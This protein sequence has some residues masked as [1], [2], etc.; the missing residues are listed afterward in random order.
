MRM[1]FWLKARSLPAGCIATI[2]F[3]EYA[4][5]RHDLPFRR[6]VSQQAKGFARVE[7]Q[8]VKFRNT[9]AVSTVTDESAGKYTASIVIVDV[10][11]AE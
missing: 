10:Y 7:F 3:R 11:P 5:Y 6:F 8:G 1:S 9:R 2:I 4:A